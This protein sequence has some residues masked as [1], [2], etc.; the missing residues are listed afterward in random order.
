MGLAVHFAPV[1]VLWVL[2]SAE[3]KNIMTQI[4]ERIGSKTLKQVRRGAWE[5]VAF[6][7]ESDLGMV[8]K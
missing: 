7:A 6:G 2:I 1:A 8:N 4:S 5:A 3:S